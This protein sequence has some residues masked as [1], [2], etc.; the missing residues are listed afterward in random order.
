M[1]T[2]IIL[3]DDH[4]MLLRG[5]SLL[6]D[7]VEGCEVVATTTDGRE[8]AELIDAHAPDVVVTD[9]VMPRF[10]G[11]EV[12]KQCKDIH[13]DVPVL[14]LTTFDDSQLVSQLIEAGASGYILKDVSAEYLA[15]A[16][17]A[18]AAGGM[19]LDPR[20]A[21]FAY[22]KNP[23]SSSSAKDNR[24][25]TTLTPTETQVAKLVAR[26]LN[27]QAIAAKLFLAEGTVK[28]HVSMLLRKME[29]DNRTSLALSLASAFGLFENNSR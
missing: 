21:G 5:L 22:G 13:P 1:D 4:D 14:V 2:R 9:A 28:N 3:I 6:F 18:A 29:A 10:D 17:K 19:V 15:N 12:V 24:K 16:A 25:V 27:N 11:L 26:G 23:A 7:T 20:I 8:V